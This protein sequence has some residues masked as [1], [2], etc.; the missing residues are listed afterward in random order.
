LILKYFFYFIFLIIVRTYYIFKLMQNLLLYKKLCYHY[1]R[2][3]EQL[4]SHKE[5]EVLNGKH[6]YLL[7]KPTSL[8]KGAERGRNV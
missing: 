1:A 5:I 6:I 4:L 8:N 3:F 7:H 2:L